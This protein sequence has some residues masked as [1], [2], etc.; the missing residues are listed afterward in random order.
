MGILKDLTDEYFGKIERME[1]TREF[2]DFG[3]ETT[4]L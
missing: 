2:I 3:G 1:D 4:V